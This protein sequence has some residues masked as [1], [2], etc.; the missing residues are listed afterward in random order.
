MHPTFKRLIAVSIAFSVVIA[1]A[2]NNTSRAVIPTMQIGDRW[3]YEQ[4]DKRT[5]IKEAEFIRNITSVGP[6]E[7]EGIENDAKLLLT[8]ELNIIESSTATITGEAKFLSFPLEVGKKWDSKYS[9]VAKPSGMKVR[10]QFEASVTS[11]DKITVPAGEFE[12]FRIDYKGYWN[13][14]TNG[15]N[16]RLKMTSWYS[17]TTRSIIKSEYEDGYNSN[18]RQL[19]EYQ[20]QP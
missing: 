10:W 17:Q 13:N 18:Y 11:I 20:I 1:T 4:N 8:P 19:V 14:D 9:F 6:S 5:G 16:G 15:R 3:K 12:A 7:I 2:Q